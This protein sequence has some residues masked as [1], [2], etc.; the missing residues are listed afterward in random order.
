MGGSVVVR[1]VPKL[2]ELKYKVSGVAVLDV[3]EGLIHLHGRG[4]T[5]SWNV[6]GSAIDALPHMHSLLNARPDG[7]DTVEEAIEWQ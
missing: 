1:A 7:F 4:I 5:A 3:V 2:L 6:I